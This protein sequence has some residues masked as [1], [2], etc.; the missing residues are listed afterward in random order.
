MARTSAQ[1]KT[2]QLIKSYRTKNGKRSGKVQVAANNNWKEL[3][4][5]LKES[6]AKVVCCLQSLLPSAVLWNNVL[7]KQNTGLFL[8]W[9][10]CLEFNPLTEVDPL[11]TIGVKLFFVSPYMETTSEYIS[12]APGVVRCLIETGLTCDFVVEFN[13]ASKTFFDSKNV[14][15]S[16]L[17]V[18]IH[19]ALD[20]ENHE[21]LQT[22]LDLIQNKI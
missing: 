17:P 11:Q 14:S 3:V 5:Q 16:K 10:E 15:E 2:Q 19:T 13:K 18:C 6:V 1:K 7:R 21:N 4:P 20:E 22:C 9:T 8:I 12:I